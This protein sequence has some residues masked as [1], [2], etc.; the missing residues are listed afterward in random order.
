M[1]HEASVRL[2]TVIVTKY[3]SSNL[4]L[5]TLKLDLFLMFKSSIFYFLNIQ[6]GQIDMIRI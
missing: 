5:I 6:Q 3:G 2:S 4:T 1:E